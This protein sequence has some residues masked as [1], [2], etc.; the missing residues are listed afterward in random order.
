M[1]PES[2]QILSAFVAE[3]EPLR[4]ELD[5]AKRREARLRGDGGSP[6][7]LPVPDRREFLREVKHVIDHIEDLDPMPALLVVHV[8]NVGDIRRRYGRQAADLALTLLH[9]LPTPCTRDAVGSL[10]GDDFGV[11]L[12]LAA[13][14]TLPGALSRSANG[15]RP[16]RFRGRTPLWPSNR[17][18]AGLK[19]GPV[20]Q[21]RRQWS[22]RS[23][24]A[25]LLKQ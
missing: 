22:P 18:S 13:P 19:C 25:R 20:G 23:P 17:W 9:R 8:A 21:R 4:A 16:T 11:I 14:K 15:W 12:F 10:G 2:Q 1:S 7:F 24:S 6:S 5:A 3:M